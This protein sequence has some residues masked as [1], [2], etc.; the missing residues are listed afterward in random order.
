MPT[1]INIL[2]FFGILAELAVVW[3][4]AH[5]GLGSQF[6]FFRLYLAA[7]AAASL[8]TMFFVS[9]LKSPD[10]HG[11]IYVRWVYLSTVFE[12]F[13]IQELCTLALKPFPAIQAASKRTLQASWVILIAV[14]AAWFWYLSLQPVARFPILRAAIRYQDATSVCFALFIFFFLAFLS[15]MPVPLSRNHLNHSFLVGALYLCLALARFLTEFGTF[16][17][18]V[19][20]GNYIA[21]GAALLVCLVWFVG[22]KPGNDDSLNT[23]RGPVN[24]AEAEKMLSRLSEL[25]ATLAR[26]HPFSHR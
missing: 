21:I 19:Q 1:P 26:S 18:Q 24:R 6:R 22:I 16:G 10:W 25:N 8:L 13:V 7:S 5:T 17:Q 20:L 4:I 2:W 15:W 9:V 3:K 23:P 12:F 14:F 11:Y